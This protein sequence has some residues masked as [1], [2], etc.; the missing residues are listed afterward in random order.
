MRP[1]VT[2]ALLPALVAAGS[3]ACSEP[4]SVDVSLLTVTA[5]L[6]RDSLTPADTLRITVTVENPSRQRVEYVSGC[7][8]RWEVRD[9]LGNRV[10]SGPAGCVYIPEGPTPRVVLAPGEARPWRYVWTGE[11]PGSGF[12]PVDPGRYSVVGS[13]NVPGGARSEA[14]WVEVLPALT[15]ALDVRPAVAGVGDTVIVTASLT[16]RTIISVRLNVFS[17]CTFAVQAERDDMPYADVTVCDYPVDRRITLEPGLELA[18]T[19]E[20]AV[21]E[22]GDYVLIGYLG[23][24]TLE[25][26]LKGTA[27]LIV[28]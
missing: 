10:A 13:I 9:S 27:S 5:T 11:R 24:P 23:F 7:G 6:D 2:A 28:R 15:F 1:R 21:D 16:N 19:V 22:P 17:T 12:D 25:P 8:P 3:I 26:A 4:L 18:D 14:A 20:W